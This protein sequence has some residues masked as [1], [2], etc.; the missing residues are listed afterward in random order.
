[1]RRMPVNC[2]G[3]LLVDCFNKNFNLIENCNC[4]KIVIILIKKN[5]FQQNDES[6]LFDFIVSSKS[7]RQLKELEHVNI[8]S[9]C[10]K[11]EI[12]FVSTNRDKF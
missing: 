7:S 12:F 8:A 1:M 5:I 2:D 11:C 10:D 3:K 6:L 4:I 9:V